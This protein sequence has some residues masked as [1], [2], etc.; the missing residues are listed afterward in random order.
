MQGF[1][2]LPMQYIFCLFWLGCLSTTVCKFLVT[3]NL[4]AFSQFAAYVPFLRLVIVNDH[5]V[6]F[7]VFAANVKLAVLLLQFPFKSIQADA[8]ISLSFRYIIIL[9]GTHSKQYISCYRHRSISSRSPFKINAKE[10]QT[11]QLYHELMAVST[12]RIR[13]EVQARPSVDRRPRTK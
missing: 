12:I 10:I 1:E 9:Q 8:C 7:S 13:R 5:Y 4:S 3:R 11:M 2:S 6:V